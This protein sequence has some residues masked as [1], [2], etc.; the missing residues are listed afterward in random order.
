M[1]W[2]RGLQA[3][4]I[5]LIIASKLAQIPGHAA[6][7]PA[8]RSCH[9]DDADDSTNGREAG[10]PG[11]GHDGPIRLSILIIITTCVCC[12]C[13]IC[14]ICRCCWLLR[15]PP[16]AHGLVP[17]WPSRRWPSLLSAS[18][19]EAC[20]NDTRHP[21]LFCPSVPSA[22]CRQ[23]CLI[24]RCRQGLPECRSRLATSRMDSD[25]ENKET[26]RPAQ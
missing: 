23:P 9:R 12:I 17:L 26:S 5:G 22:S 6:T 13:C 11:Q 2:L 20:S 3:A 25:S 21:V 7:R 16:P 24:N 4:R 19:D 15:L 10:K 18:P 1:Q 14:C 8:S